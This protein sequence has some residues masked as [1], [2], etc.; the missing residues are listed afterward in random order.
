MKFELTV[1]NAAGREGQQA[2]TVEAREVEI[3]PLEKI[4]DVIT[5]LRSRAIFPKVILGLLTGVRRAEIDAMR[6]RNVDLAEKMISVR[7]SIEETK[8]HGP[9]FKSTKTKKGLR[10]ITLPDIV[11]E[12]LSEHRRGQLEERLSLGLGKPP[13]DALVFPPRDDGP[14]YPKDLLGEWKEA[15]A[16]VGIDPPVTFHALRHTHAR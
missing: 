8:D 5:K 12:T 1:R 3:L 16:I 10:E 9:R 14:Q 7:E 4:G 15:C 6:W 2:P 11:I 13:A